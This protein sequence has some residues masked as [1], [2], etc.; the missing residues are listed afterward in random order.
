MFFVL[1]VLLLNVLPSKITAFNRL[2]KLKEL[3][4]IP[5]VGRLIA[6]LGISERNFEVLV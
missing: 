2:I 3:G 4:N 1:K 5:L 6:S